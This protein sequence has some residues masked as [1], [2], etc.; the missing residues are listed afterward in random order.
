MDHDYI[1]SHSTYSFSNFAKQIIVYISGVVVQKLT[2]VLKCDVY[3]HGLC[4]AE[5]ECF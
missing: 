2:N 4:A 1:G 3:K 5:K